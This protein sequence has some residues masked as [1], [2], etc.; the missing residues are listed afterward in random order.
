MTLS[1]RVKKCRET[2]G[3]SKAQL[4]KKTGFPRATI[5]HIEQRNS[6]NISARTLKKLADVLGVSADY[7]LGRIKKVNI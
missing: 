2:L 3:L 6:D 1:G 5:T 7:L 4:A